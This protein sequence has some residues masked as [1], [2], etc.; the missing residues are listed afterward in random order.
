MIVFV[1]NY[2]I[3]YRVKKR[4]FSVIFVKKLDVF[5]KMD[6]VKLSLFRIITKSISPARLII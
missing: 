2:N 6:I 1:F 3:K 4:V 5:N